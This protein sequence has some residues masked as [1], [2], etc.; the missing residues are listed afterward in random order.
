M[1]QL[2]LDELYKLHSDYV[3]DILKS[4]YVRSPALIRGLC[5]QFPKLFSSYQEVENLL[6]MSD[7][8]K[9]NWGK[10]PLS[11]LTHDLHQNTIR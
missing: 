6:Y 3:M 10:R 11:K 7:I 4:K 9:E 5:N 8:R 1:K 2:Y